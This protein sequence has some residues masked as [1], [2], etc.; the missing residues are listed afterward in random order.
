MINKCN[1]YWG[2]SYIRG[3][4]VFVGCCHYI[5]SLYMVCEFICDETRFASLNKSIFM[6]DR[7]LITHLRPLMMF[8]YVQITRT[9]FY[10][11]KKTT[12]RWI[13]ARWIKSL[14]QECSLALSHRYNG[15]W[16]DM[17]RRDMLQDMI[18]ISYRHIMYCRLIITMTTPWYPILPGLMEKTMQIIWIP[19]II[20]TWGIPRATKHDNLSF[21]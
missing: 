12:Y 14:V 5:K 10:M 6:W 15:V 16:Y 21:W 3:L 7:H 4:T 19:I 18:G 2:A 20:S 9:C 8:M 17:T 11:N 1:A 13:G